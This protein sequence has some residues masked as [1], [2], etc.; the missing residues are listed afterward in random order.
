M[1]IKR[2][3]KVRKVMLCCGSDAWEYVQCYRRF[4]F[5]PLI[6]SV[7]LILSTP[8]HIFCV[9]HVS[10]SLSVSPGPAEQNPGSGGQAYWWHLLIVLMGKPLC[11]FNTSCSVGVCSWEHTGSCHH[12]GLPPQDHLPPQLRTPMDSPLNYEERSL[13]VLE[14]YKW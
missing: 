2:R 7:S 11:P 9:H 3:R 5:L 12:H 13:W 6:F 1:R 4:I 10:V 8:T 14:N